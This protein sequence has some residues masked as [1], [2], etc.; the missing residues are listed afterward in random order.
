[1]RSRR[2]FRY[3]IAQLLLAWAVVILHAQA[4]VERLEILERQDF[5]ARTSFG[6]SGAYEKLRGRAWFA[7]D[8]AAPANAQIADLTCP[9]RWARRHIQHRFFVP[10]P[11]DASRGNNTSA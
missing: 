8:P 2:T 1:M 5:A 4:R 7:L 9:T 3:C 10:R 11:V 6:S